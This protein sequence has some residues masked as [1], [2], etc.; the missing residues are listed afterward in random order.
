MA[1]W[2][3][4]FTDSLFPNNVTTNMLFFQITNRFRPPVY[5]CTHRRCIILVALLD[6]ETEV[7]GQTTWGIRQWTG[8][9][10]SMTQFSCRKTG[11]DMQPRGLLEVSLA[12]SKRQPAVLDLQTARHKDS[13]SVTACL[14][15]QSWYKSLYGQCHHCCRIFFHGKTDVYL[16]CST[17]MLQLMYWF[18]FLDSNIYQMLKKFFF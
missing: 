9:F 15:L 16:S 10:I 7:W 5:A 3:C 17:V 1:E 13:L 11:K 2:I 14:L 18:C 12:L 4:V 8:Y 6:R